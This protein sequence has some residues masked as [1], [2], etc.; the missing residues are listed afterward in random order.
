MPSL[1]PLGYFLLLLLN[2]QCRVQFTSPLKKKNFFPILFW[3][4]GFCCHFFLKRC[5]F[6]FASPSLFNVIFHL[7][8]L[9]IVRAALAEHD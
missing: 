3:F 7:N 1:A 6:T 9:L 5:F 8:C 2:T 4:V